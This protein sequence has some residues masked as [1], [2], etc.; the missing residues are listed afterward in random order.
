MKRNRVLAV[1]LP[2][3]CVLGIW[4][5]IKQPGHGDLDGGMEGAVLPED[6]RAEEAA[7]IGDGRIEEADFA[8]EGGKFAEE[9]GF[10]GEDGNL[11]EEAEGE[12]REGETKGYGL[13][14]S[15]KERA[16]AEKD[17]FAKMELVRDLL[18]KYE[19]EDGYGSSIEIP[20]EQIQKAVERIAERGCCVLTSE[21]YADMR[22][23]ER[24]KAFLEGVARGECGGEILYKISGD[25]RISRLK[26]Y[27]D[28]KDMYV[29]TAVVSWQSEEA[30]VLNYLDH[31]QIEEWRFTGKGWF[32]YKL[33]VPRY[34]EVTEVVDGSCMVRVIPMSDE[35]REMSE[36][37][38]L[39]VAYKGNNLFCHDWD[40]AH[41]EELDYNGLYEYFYRM[42]YE[43]LFPAEDHRGGIPE[44]DF[45][46][47]MAEYLPVTGEELR[48]YA[49]Y[50]AKS[51]T[52]AW[53]MQEYSN[54]AP[55]FFSASVPEVVQI[56]ENEDGTVTLTVDAVCE[57]LL[58]DDAA[59][60]HEVTVKFEEDGSFRYLGN[61]VMRCSMG[62]MPKYHDRIRDRG[63]G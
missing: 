5:G 18:P 8:G 59:V 60:T 61:R 52:Y 50:D 35:N 45:E 58:C 29:I 32:A 30:P 57:M 4:L 56:R 24:F 10:A 17:C 36:K 43:E 39:Q 28:G 40:E 55:V 49:V 3:G 54:D 38:V 42:K 53:E 12:E 44:E 9:A 51:R 48:R 25:G 27:C 34:P 41:M 16:E 2:L 62:D 13:P 46:S 6:G 23:H 15:E 20:G 47:L 1:F 7:Y 14:V 21:P 37:C 31:T 11:A 22:N 33:C 19:G 26:Y 63:E